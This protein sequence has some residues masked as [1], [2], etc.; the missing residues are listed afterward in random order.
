MKRASFV[1]IVS[2][3]WPV[4]REAITT[5]CHISPGGVSLVQ[6]NV[7]APEQGMGQPAICQTVIMASAGAHNTV[8]R[9]RF[10]SPM[11]T[12]NARKPSP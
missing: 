9:S 2:G 3:R 12:N 8:Q 11:P 6:D 1:R 10:S 5:I 7:N 4:W